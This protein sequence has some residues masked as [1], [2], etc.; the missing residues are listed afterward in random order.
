MT[1][2]MAGN[3]TVLLSG[4]GA[5]QEDLQKLASRVAALNSPMEERVPGHLVLPPD[6]DPWYMRLREGEH[7][8]ARVRMEHP[9]PVSFNPAYLVNLAQPPEDPVEE[10][11]LSEMLRADYSDI[12]HRVAAVL[13][14][15]AHNIFIDAVMPYRINP[16]PRRLSRAERK[17][18]KLKK[19]S[20]NLK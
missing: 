1:F 2:Q 5:S 20:G 13:G 3:I 18:R 16:R 11:A 4:E 7:P 6:I 9:L 14:K 12:E 15:T 8:T 10:L 19:M 17:L